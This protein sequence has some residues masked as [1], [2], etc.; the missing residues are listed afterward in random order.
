M[1][2]LGSVGECNKRRGAAMRCN[3]HD[4]TRLV[5][6]VPPQTQPPRVKVSQARTPITINKRAGALSSCC[7][8]VLLFGS[9]AAD[10][11]NRLRLN[12]AHVDNQFA[13]GMSFFQLAMGV[14][15]LCQAEALRIQ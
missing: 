1:G 12:L 6:P 7:A 3:W 2:R 14:G 13:S 9:A 8:E 15:H 10:C 4:T 11:T 5:R